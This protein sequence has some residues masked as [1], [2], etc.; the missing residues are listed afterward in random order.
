MR[1]E[2]IFD[3]LYALTGGHRIL[4]S[5]WCENLESVDIERM[6][7]GRFLISDR[8]ATFSSLTDETNDTNLSLEEIGIPK[9]QE[10][11]ETNGVQLLDIYPDEREMFDHEWLALGIYASTDED[12]RQSVAAV[13]NCID[14]I[15]DFASL[16]GGWK[17]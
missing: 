8:Y 3:E 16:D 10:F 4:I 11:C 13:S 2:Q 5:I 7:D 6:Q 9:I 14:A 17:T 1:L 12:V 15:F